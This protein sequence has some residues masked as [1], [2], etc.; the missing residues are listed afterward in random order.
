MNKS[1]VR[2]SL[3]I[4]SLMFF[5]ALGCDQA[6]AGDLVKLVANRHSIFTTEA[7]VGVIQ[8]LFTNVPW[9][10]GLPSLLVL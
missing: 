2:K 6:Q 10:T 4:L 9:T 3:V 5:S 7:V 8:R 1:L